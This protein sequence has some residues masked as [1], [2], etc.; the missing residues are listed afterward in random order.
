MTAHNSTLG[1]VLNVLASVLFA[2]MYAYTSLLA[3]LDGAEIYGWRILLTVPCLTLMVIT[4]GHWPQVRRIFQR[5]FEERWFWAIRLVSAAL[6]GVQLWL[7]MWAPI[8]GHGLDV[9]LG[10]FLMPLVM[11]IV[12][13]LAFKDSISRLQLLA[14]ALAALGIIN[15]IA[16]A[17][18]ISW[19]VLVVSLG[20]P[21]YF[22]L[23]RVTDTNNMG[24][25]WFDMSLSL[26]VSLYFVLKGGV[27]L[28]LA[29]LASNLPWL[30]LGL[31]AISAAALGLQALSA[32]R[33]NLTLF[34]LLIYV[35]PVLL[36][37]AAVLLG[38]SIAPAQW[39]TYLAIWLA[40]LVLVVEGGLSLNGN[41]RTY[42]PSRCSREGG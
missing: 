31:G 7:F 15:Q 30:V 9:S 22:W 19:P 34:G 24:G 16:I 20:Y 21:L 5:L 2:V 38:D 8:N 35:E 17:K 1:V 37:V 29:G 27:V 36:V 11:V 10:Y 28:G 14:C 25:L 23:R 33:L 6:L 41:R 26:P 12:G 13:R 40:V 39:P 18:A 42:S 3:P 4:S 32:P